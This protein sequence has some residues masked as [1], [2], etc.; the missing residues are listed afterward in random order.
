MAGERLKNVSVADES[1][2][3]NDFV[4]ANPKEFGTPTRAIT[5]AVD[6]GTFLNKPK[7]VGK[8]SA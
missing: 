3:V 2:Y 5:N 4:A 6:L 7:A 1:K 8:R